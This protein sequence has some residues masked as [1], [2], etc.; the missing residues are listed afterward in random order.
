[1][2]QAGKWPNSLTADA[3]VAVA[4]H[5][6]GAS[7]PDG[8]P[9]PTVLEPIPL[10]PDGSRPVDD[11]NFR[12]NAFTIHPEARATPMQPGG[13]VASACCSETSPVYRL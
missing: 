8:A 2:Q 6:V 12:F 9:W 11:G 3:A 10:S 5:R 7:G 13:R 1:M 4:Y